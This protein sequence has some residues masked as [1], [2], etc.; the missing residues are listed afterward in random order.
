MEKTGVA[1][2]VEFLKE[3]S[4]GFEFLRIAMADKSN[5][6][7]FDVIKDLESVSFK[8]VKGKIASEPAIILTLKSAVP[9]SRDKMILPI[10]YISEARIDSMSVIL[11]LKNKL[12]VEFIE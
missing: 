5:G 9:G 7:A 2:A 10:S 1:R 6:F 11:A 12:I 4:G 8:E 3:Y